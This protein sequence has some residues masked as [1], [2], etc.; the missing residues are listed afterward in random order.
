MKLD[1]KEG[2]QVATYARYNVLF[3]TNWLK[4]EIGIDQ[5]QTNLAKIAEMDNPTNMD[6]LAEIGR[7]AAKKQVQ[8]EHFPAAFDV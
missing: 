6:E 8:S 5:P 2:P 4:T 7:L 3:E 1:S